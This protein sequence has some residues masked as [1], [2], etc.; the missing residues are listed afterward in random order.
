VHRVRILPGT[1]LLVRDIA[2]PLQNEL[3]ISWIEKVVFT[4]IASA[5]GAFRDGIR[6]LN[7]RE[8]LL[9]R[10]QEGQRVRVLDSSSVRYADSSAEPI[11]ALAS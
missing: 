5:S 3:G 8:I 9:Q 7:G 11:A 1:R 10:L 2:E 6:F 4:E